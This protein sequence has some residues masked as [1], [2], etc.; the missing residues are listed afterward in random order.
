M[1]RKKAGDLTSNLLFYVF[2]KVMAISWP[3]YD[4]TIYNQ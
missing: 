1:L 2:I 3:M 4:Y